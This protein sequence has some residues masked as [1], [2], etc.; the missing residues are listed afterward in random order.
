MWLRS[1]VCP[2]KRIVL[3]YAVPVDRASECATVRHALFRTEKAGCNMDSSPTGISKMEHG[4]HRIQIAEARSQSDVAEAV[5]C[6]REFLA[7]LHAR[8]APREWIVREYFS[9][10]ALEKELSAL[11]VAYAAPEAAILLA[12]VDDTRAGCVMFRKLEP[13]ICEMKRMYIK[14]AFQRM[15]LGRRFATELMLLARQRGYLKM[16]LDTGPLQPE[17]QSLYRSLGFYPIP[18]YYDCPEPLRPE[19]LFMEAC[20][21]A[22]DA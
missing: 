13:G 9:E 21:E 14:P 15:G 10:M 3:S 17:A 8:Y 7:W 19:L 4:A 22:C 18:C 16:R 1:D 20:L 6:L 12:S 11:P 5:E 2:G